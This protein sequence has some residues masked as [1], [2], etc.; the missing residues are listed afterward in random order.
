MFCGQIKFTSLQRILEGFNLIIQ[1]FDNSTPSF[2]R[3]Y[4]VLNPQ[5]SPT[6][7]LKHPIVAFYLKRGEVEVQLRVL[8][9]MMQAF[10][11]LV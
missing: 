5:R 9:C 7:L 6:L 2:S 10:Q 11:I 1:C 4:S 8:S 3:N